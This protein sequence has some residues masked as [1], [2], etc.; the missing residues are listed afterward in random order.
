MIQNNSIINYIKSTFSKTT[1]EKSLL[2]FKLKNGT[3]VMGLST[4]DRETFIEN[5]VT[6]HLMQSDTSESY[7]K[8][9]DWLLINDT[10]KG[11][12]IDNKD[13]LSI[14]GEADDFGKYC[15]NKY[16]EFRTAQKT[17]LNLHVVNNTSEEFVI[18]NTDFLHL[19]T[20]AIH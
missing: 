1:V 12:H 6:Y 16:L 15:Y 3:N 13:I 2:C 11:V 5:P 10:R 19:A 17:Q 8:M 14:L 20:N 7:I 9:E 18:E 4:N